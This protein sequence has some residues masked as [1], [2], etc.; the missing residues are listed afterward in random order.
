[1]PVV[2][3][4]PDLDPEVEQKLVHHLNELP[5]IKHL[6]S[7][8]EVIQSP[9]LSHNWLVF[10]ASQLLYLKNSPFPLTFSAF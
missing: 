5:D 7:T 1:V 8:L 4:I 2:D 6:S 9:S 10:A 3:V